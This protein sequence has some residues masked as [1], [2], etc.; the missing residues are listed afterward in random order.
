M[1]DFFGRTKILESD[2]EEY[3]LNVQKAG[4]LF[5]EA[6][7][8]FIGEDWETFQEREKEIS[9]VENDADYLRR[10]IKRKLYTHMLIPDARGDVLALVETIDE[11]VDT[12][13]KVVQNFS[14]EKPNIPNFLKADFIKLADFSQKAVDELVRAAK[15]FFSKIAEANDYIN[16]VYFFEHEID[17]LE[18]RM[19]RHIFSAS[20]IGGL[21]ER[22]Q[23]R[24][25][26][27]KMATVSDSAEMVCDRLSVYVIK[28]SI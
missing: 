8:D 18:E 27:E 2:I 9:I 1:L 28:R 21:A 23:L 24:Y 22:I 16:K 13:K 12:T 5:N 10:T 7:K 6:V 11:V 17:K 3:L 25:F 26:I 15:S 20:E 19:K 14:I 4:L